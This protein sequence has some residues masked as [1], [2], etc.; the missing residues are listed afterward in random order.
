MAIP[1]SADEIDG[2]RSRRADSRRR[3]TICTGA[4]RP[5][6]DPE[7]NKRAGAG[8]RAKWQMERLYGKYQDDAIEVP[9]REQ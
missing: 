1:L 3:A 2:N 7:F 6:P 5:G 8:R 4:A 9:F